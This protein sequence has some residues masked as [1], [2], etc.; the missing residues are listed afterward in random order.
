[1]GSFVRHPQYETSAQGTVAQ[2]IFIQD[3]TTDIID[4]YFHQELNT[5]TLSAPS[6]VDAR[7]FDLTA[8]HG[9]V[10]G[11]FLEISEDVHVSQFEILNVVTNTITVD[12]PIDHA[13]TTSAAVRVSNINMAVDGSVTPVVFQIDPIPTQEWDIVRVILVI[14]DGTAMDF[15]TFGGIPAL[16]NGCC[17]RYKNSVRENIF[18]W[19]SNGDFINRS[20]DYAIL[21]NTGQNQRSFVSRCTFAGTSKRGVAARLEG[22][23]GDELQVIIQDDLTDLTSV[24]IIAQGHEVQS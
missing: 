17:I 1:M 7:T 3:Q 11:N 10:V 22:S 2:K 12:C 20:F 24:R 6:V 13:F 14:N 19:K 23:K 15:T 5:S 4:L 18:N 21:Q 9:A 8:G 16:T